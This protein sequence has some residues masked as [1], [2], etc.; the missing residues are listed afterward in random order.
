MAL[1]DTVHTLTDAIRW[2]GCMAGFVG[3]ADLWRQM[4]GIIPRRGGE[5][6]NLPVPDIGGIG[7]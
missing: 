2:W 4:T 3:L 1:I 7:N 6:R 5:A